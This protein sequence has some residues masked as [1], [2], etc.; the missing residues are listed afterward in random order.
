MEEST[1]LKLNE[2]SIIKQD[3]D[4]VLL[5]YYVRFATKFDQDYLHLIPLL[6]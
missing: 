2:S 3:K 5:A 6:Y 1:D 4:G